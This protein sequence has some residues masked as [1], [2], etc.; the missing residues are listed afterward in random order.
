MQNKVKKIAHVTLS[1]LMA[2]VL[3]V[4]AT[5]TNYK[6]STT[7]VQNK[8]TESETYTH[9]LNNIPIAITYNSEK[10]FIS[11]F[12]S[13]TTVDLTGSN[14]LILQ[15]ETD[16]STRTLQVVADLTE[17]EPGIHTVP[18]QVV[19]LPAG[20]SATLNPSELTIKIGNKASKTYPVEGVVYSNQ[21]AAGYSVSK[22]SV[23]LE[24]VKVTTDED[25]LL[26]IDH[27]EAVATDAM[28]ISSDYSGV[29]TIQAVDSQGNVLPVVLSQS[30][31]VIQAVITKIK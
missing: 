3:F 26:L 15:R 1:V 19:N 5:T 23:N 10:Y 7:A 20:V 25:T 8:E 24:S 13:T 4:Y 29:A 2:L 22:V 9:N 12:S 14:R 30:E 16:D 28:N 27:V 21:L 17:L 6:N 11:G 31:A 18:L